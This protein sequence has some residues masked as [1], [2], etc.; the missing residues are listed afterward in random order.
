MKKDLLSLR[1]GNLCSRPLQAPTA[2]NSGQNYVKAKIG[3]LNGLFGC[4]NIKSTWIH[5]SNG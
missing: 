5:Y 2:Q 3:W 1:G 4:K